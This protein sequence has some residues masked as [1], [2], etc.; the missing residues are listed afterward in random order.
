MDDWVDE[1][2]RLCRNMEQTG[3]AI[4]ADCDDMTRWLQKYA[5]ELIDAAKMVQ[6]PPECVHCTDRDPDINHWKTCDNHP[7]RK[8]I[9]SLLALLR[10]VGVHESSGACNECGMMARENARTN[11]VC[12][13]PNCELAA[14]LKDS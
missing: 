6:R 1:G 8:R 10:R 13:H 9:D 11:D 12:I 7:A 2:D 3:G 5:R 4:D 14:A